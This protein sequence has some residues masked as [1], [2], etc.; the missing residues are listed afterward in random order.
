ASADQILIVG[1]SLGT[2]VSALLAAELSDEQISPKG[3]VLLSPF[4]SISKV[5]ETYSIL[6][7]VPLIKPLAMIPWAANL[8]KRTIIHTFDT[9]TLVPRIKGPV[10]LAHAENDW[11]IPYSHSKALFDAFLA[12]LL[13]SAPA[14]P[15][16]AVSLGEAQWA[17]FVA[18]R[19]ERLGARDRLVTSVEMRHFG[20]VHEFTEEA[21]RKVVF[22]QTLAGGHDYL[23][24]QEGVQDV[25]GRMFGFFEM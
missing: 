7:V 16:N 18:Q 10:L 24:V 4:S 14:L 23:G 9:E 6:G 13:P 8:V 15:P 20:T 12:P 11:D 25:M 2:G 3:V 19:T 1:H 5:L 17:A 21:G 22:V